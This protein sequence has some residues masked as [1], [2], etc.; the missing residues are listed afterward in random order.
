MT[1]YK[2]AERRN[3]K[4][5]QAQFINIAPMF[6]DDGLRGQYFKKFYYTFFASEYSGAKLLIVLVFIITLISAIYSNNAIA[7]FLAAISGFWCLSMAFMIYIYGYNKL[8]SW[9]YQECI[10]GKRTP[11]HVLNKPFDAKN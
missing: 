7:G 4:C 10:N 3:R 6:E 8:F 9:P 5:A 11:S 2:D 1:H